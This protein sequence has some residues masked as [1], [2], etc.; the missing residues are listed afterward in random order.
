MPETPS[1]IIS[2]VEA[3]KRL[4]D[5]ANRASYSRETIFLTR[6]GKPVAVIIGFEDYQQLLKLEDARVAAIL[7]RSIGTSKGTV[8]VE[9]T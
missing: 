1:N 2:I 7:Q 8:P 6:R 9:S 4:S 3:R 5:L